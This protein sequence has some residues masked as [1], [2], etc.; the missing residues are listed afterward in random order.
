MNGNETKGTKT[1]HCI[2]KGQSLNV[3]P[4]NIFVCQADERP[5]PGR[6]KR[7]MGHAKEQNPVGAVVVSPGLT[8]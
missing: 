3:G 5:P 8:F 1:T 4:R 7:V 6:P 2:A